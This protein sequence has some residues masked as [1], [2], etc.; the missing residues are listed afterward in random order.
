MILEIPLLTRQHAISTVQHLCGGMDIGLSHLNSCT[1][2]LS[3]YHII[4]Y[5]LTYVLAYKK[6]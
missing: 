6:L 1:T 2:V 5:I 3:A 4:N